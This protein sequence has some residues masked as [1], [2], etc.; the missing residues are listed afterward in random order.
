M[1]HENG[2][3]NCQAKSDLLTVTPKGLAN[4]HTKKGLANCHKKGLAIVTR[5]GLANCRAKKDWLT[6]TQKGTG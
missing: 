4:C 2:V 3:A 5:K 1:S 6:V